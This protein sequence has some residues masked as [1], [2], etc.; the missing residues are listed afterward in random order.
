MCVEIILDVDYCD[1][2]EIKD[3]RW[4]VKNVESHYILEKV[5]EHDDDGCWIFDED[6]ARLLNLKNEGWILKNAEWREK[7]K[8]KGREEGRG[9]WR[10]FLKFLNQYELVSFFCSLSLN[11]NNNASL[12]VNCWEKKSYDP[13]SLFLLYQLYWLFR[14]DQNS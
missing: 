10:F 12:C 3:N 9:L 1:D 6:D 5:M 4:C 13:L 14:V 7:M 11:K 2:A 8:M